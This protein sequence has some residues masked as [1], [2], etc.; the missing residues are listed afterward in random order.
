MTMLQ[1]LAEEGEGVLR[2]C[3]YN[4][5]MI[6]I[7]TDTSLISLW[8]IKYGSFTI[9]I[10]LS[11]GIIA[12]PI[13][14]ETI[15]VMAGVFMHKGKL[16]ILSTILFA[17]AGTMT[18][19]TVSYLLG[20][21]A[22]ISLIQRYGKFVGITESHLLKAHYW[23]ER[24]GG[25][26]LTIGYFIPGIRPLSGIFAG[27]TDLKYSHFAF[28]AYTGALFWVSLF[29][30]LGYFVGT[31][32]LELLEKLKGNNLIL[33]ALAL[34]ILVIIFLIMRRHLKRSKHDKL[35]SFPRVF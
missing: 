2:K 8:L 26:I 6:D 23:F 9:F 16:N 31:Y 5:I 11:L 27:I 18:G 14:A 12:L 24:F 28:Y 35:T 29:L 19:I 20:K 25:W 4:K 30:S 22:G 17:Y 15:M 3:M 34:G 32:V 7:F 10:V 21:I 1:A 13:P 33:I